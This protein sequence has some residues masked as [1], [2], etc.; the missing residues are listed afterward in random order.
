MLFGSYMSGSSNTS[1]T[2]P[3][4]KPPQQCALQRE[5]GNSSGFLKTSRAG[6]F[7]EAACALDPR[8]ERSNMGIR[9]DRLSRAALWTKHPIGATMLFGSYMSGSSNTPGTMPLEN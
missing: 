4:E 5:N 6:L 3:L 1:G 2:M 7:Y 9:R 8:Y